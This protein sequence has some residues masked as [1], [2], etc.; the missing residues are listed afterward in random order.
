MKFSLIRAIP[1]LLAGLASVAWPQAPAPAPA[2]AP[3]AAEQPEDSLV[4]Y[5]SRG[6]LALSQRDYAAAARFYR[7]YRD[8]AYH[9]DLL[10]DAT[11]LLVRSLIY[12][13]RIEEAAQAVDAVPEIMARI[14][15]EG[16]R[17]L[18]PVNR[19]RHLYWMGRVKFLQGN[20]DEALGHFLEAEKEP[21]PRQLQSMARL[22]AGEC[23]VS[24]QQWA[25]AEEVMKK[26]VEADLS[27]DQQWRA[28]LSL[29]RAKVMQGKYR[30]ADSLIGTW[31]PT[32]SGIYRVKLGMMQ[33]VSFLGQNFV[34]NAFS[35]YRDIFAK[36]VDYLNDASNYEIIRGLG[37]A[38]MKEKDFESAIV[39]FERMLPLVKV[40][41]Q[42]QALVLDLAEAA[43][44]AGDTAQA[45]R[46]LEFFIELYPNDARLTD[47][48]FRIA[49]LY[50]KLANVD[51]AI[52]W[53]GR[54]YGNQE[55]PPALRYQSAH[56]LAWIYRD[57]IKDYTKAIDYFDEAGK[58]NVS[59]EDLA[60]SVFYAAET[61][62]LIEEYGNAALQ[63]GTV[64]DTWPSST[65]AREARFKQGISF[66][67]NKQFALAATAFGQFIESWPNDEPR[68]KEALLKK[69]LSERHANLNP[70][71]MNTLRDYAKRYPDDLQNAPYALLRGSEAASAAEYPNDAITLLSLIIDTYPSSEYFPYAL[72]KRAYL[73][74]SMHH[75]DEAVQDSLMFLDRYGKSIP[76]L[77]P[78]VLLWL[79]DHYA[80]QQKYADAEHYFEAVVR[81]FPES[82]DAPIAIYEA[83]KNAFRQREFDKA[84]EGL[85]R[86]TR[87]YPDAPARVRAQASFL[88]ADILSFSGD[89]LGAARLFE[90]CIDL[91][92]G[93]R[94]YYAALGR[95]G[96]SHYN[97]G[98]A[99]E[100]PEAK[101]HF[102]Q[103]IVYFTRL[104]NE[105][106]ASGETRDPMVEKAR[107]RKAKVHELLG[108]VDLARA[109][110]ETIFYSYKDSEI[111]K[112]I[113]DWYYFAR[114]GFDLA[115]LYINAGQ[116]LS[117][118][119]IYNRLAKSSIPVAADAAE[120]AAA[121]SSSTTPPLPAP[122]PATAPAVAPTRDEGG[123]A[124]PASAL[125][126]PNPDVPPAPAPTPPPPPAANGE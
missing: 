29:T 45:I 33:I 96:E 83:A 114:A 120:R 3:A 26:V 16:Q 92:P 40:E 85:D 37:H 86:L 27:D 90:S 99:L 95:L 119:V 48:R 28:V 38:L 62:S 9:Q 91:V 64:A 113:F 15:P 112:R 19:H 55:A 10:I 115:H 77:T 81:D 121:L 50:E 49:Q 7:Q 125:P 13:N 94:L 118:I 57:K 36:E 69:G 75:H 47:L 23:Y 8:A 71:A 56:A 117:A 87:Q 54:V 74:L 24:K 31:F 72:Y 58:L 22:G 63:Y 88:H 116:S 124:P 43:S 14:A 78:D 101:G 51:E 60:R 65:F 52:V 66:Y 122:T 59:E 39:V 82:H 1:L 44:G 5:K 73:H 89:Y 46:Y 30:D 68:V 25:A 108:E 97:I 76:S 109:E 6:D 67:L 32:A 79:G 111:R 35:F 12:L 93:T 102:Q 42:K 4:A 80:T 70:T 105:I 53:Y 104:I 84:L 21:S 107:Y 98:N 20:I 100:G 106:E 123:V 17:D 61:R 34:G 2:P 18:T 41:E 103:A 126:A 110:Y 11:E